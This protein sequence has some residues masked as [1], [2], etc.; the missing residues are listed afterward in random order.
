[1]EYKKRKEEQVKMREKKHEVG[2]QRGCSEKFRLVEKVTTTGE[3]SMTHYGSK[4]PKYY[5]LS[6]G[7]CN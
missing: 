5:Q 7:K 2:K 3:H 6:L 1:M 4:W